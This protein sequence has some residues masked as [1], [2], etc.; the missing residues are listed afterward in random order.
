M[1]YRSQYEDQM[2]H[3]QLCS[4]EKEKW[5]LRVKAALYTC[6]PRIFGMGFDICLHYRP[7]MSA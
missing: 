7:L 4:D 1:V 5:Q 6:L 3:A 2:L